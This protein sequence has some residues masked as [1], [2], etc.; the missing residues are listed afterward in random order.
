MHASPSARKSTKVVERVA[1]SCRKCE[2]KYFVTNIEDSLSGSF[3][4]GVSSNK[5]GF[6]A[7]IT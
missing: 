2:L 6:T 4:K 5:T 7:S 3:E 1:L